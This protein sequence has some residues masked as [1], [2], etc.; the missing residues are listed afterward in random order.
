MPACDLSKKMFLCQGALEQANEKT[1]C[2]NV[3][4]SRQAK[5]TQ[6]P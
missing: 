5:A 2:A 6:Q 4:A 3:P 1:S